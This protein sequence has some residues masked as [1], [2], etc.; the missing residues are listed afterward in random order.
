MGIKAAK[1]KQQFI[2]VIA[3]CVDDGG[4]TDLKRNF[5]SGG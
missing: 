2:R 5:T 4:C 1:D 3:E